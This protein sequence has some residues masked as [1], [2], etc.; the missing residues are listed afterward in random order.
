MRLLESYFLLLV[1]VKERNKGR[2]K[3]TMKEKIRREVE[4]EKKEK[5]REIEGEKKEKR[6]EI[7]REKKDQLDKVLKR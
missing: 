1:K 2:K 7:E 5:R 3:E 4:R 6:R